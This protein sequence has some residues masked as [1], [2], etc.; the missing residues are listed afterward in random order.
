VISVQK[1]TLT[2]VCLVKNLKIEKVKLIVD[3]RLAIK[4]QV[5][6]VKNYLVNILVIPVQKLTLKIVYLVKTL[7]TE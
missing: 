1:L 7:Q 2:N 5:K 3:V 4:N 6:S